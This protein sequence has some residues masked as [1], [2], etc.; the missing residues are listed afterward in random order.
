VI[1]GGVNEVLARQEIRSMG[2]CRGAQTDICVLVIFDPS[3]RAFYAAKKKNLG[4]APSFKKLCSIL[5]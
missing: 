4:Q 1:S 2:L 3:F 5:P